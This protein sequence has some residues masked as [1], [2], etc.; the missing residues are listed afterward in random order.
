[1]T[2]WNFVLF[3][4]LR[5]VTMF[6]EQNRGIKVQGRRLQYILDMPNKPTNLMCPKKCLWII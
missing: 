1:M 2:S 4:I 3:Y 6:A 5:F